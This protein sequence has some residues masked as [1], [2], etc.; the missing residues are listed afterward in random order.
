M[1]LLSTKSFLLI[2]FA[3]ENVQLSL[4]VFPSPLLCTYIWWQTAWANIDARDSTID[5][6]RHQLTAE[7]SRMKT[8]QE[9]TPLLETKAMNTFKAKSSSI[10]KYGST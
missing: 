1:N 5:K 4:C 2:Y 10:T 6:L 8:Y 7:L 9:H 3:S